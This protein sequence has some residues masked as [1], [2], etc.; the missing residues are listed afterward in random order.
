LYMFVEAR[1][2]VARS[3]AQIAR[4]FCWWRYYFSFITFHPLS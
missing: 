3:C 2:A 4:S 1:S